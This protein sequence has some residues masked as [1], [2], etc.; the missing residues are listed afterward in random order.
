VHDFRPNQGAAANSRP[1]LRFTMMDSLNIHLASDAPCP[2]VAE[3]D[4]CRHRAMSIVARLFLAVLAGA[5]VFAGCSHPPRPSQTAAPD[6]KPEGARLRTAEAI[7]IAKQA[8]ERQGVRLRDYKEPEAHYEFT[9]K[10]KSWFVFF[11]GR[12]AMPGNHFSVSVDD[13]TGK[14]QFFWG[15]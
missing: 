7:Q 3:L 8:A 2:A 10:D 9:H 13:Q 11:D 5:L 4:R 12:V 6:T 14:T 1:V 15:R